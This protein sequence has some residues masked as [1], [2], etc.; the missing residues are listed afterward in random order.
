M[1]IITGR[2]KGR[3]IRTVRDLSVRPATDRVKQTIFNM[4]AHRIEMQGIVV[5]D[6]FAGSGN[7][8]FEALSRG[9]SR[10]TFVENNRPAVD[11]IERNVRELGCEASS[12]IHET[13]VVSFIKAAA[14]AYDLIFADPPY[15]FGQTRE[16]PELILSR[17]LLK[18]DGYLI[19]EHAKNIRFAATSLYRTTAS[20]QFGRTLVT[21]FQYPQPATADRS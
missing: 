19:M 4:L 17:N 9:A 21:F 1:R 2:Y 13:D 18:R 10:V 15:E 16:L 7:L 8:G 6:L 14:T 12:E 3:I 20:R 5:L 11:F